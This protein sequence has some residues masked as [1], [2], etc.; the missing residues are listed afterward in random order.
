[1]KPLIIIYFLSLLS[2]TILGQNQKIDYEC[3]QYENVINEIT[4]TKEYR[5]YFKV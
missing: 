4:K 2:E 5:K 1:M 3:I